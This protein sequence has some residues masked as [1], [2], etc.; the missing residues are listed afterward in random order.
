MSSACGCDTVVKRSRVDSN[1]SWRCRIRTRYWVV[2]TALA[3]AQ[4]LMAEGPASALTPAPAWTFVEAALSSRDAA[5]H[6]VV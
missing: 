4:A 3:R 5:C 1:Q 6:F 2:R